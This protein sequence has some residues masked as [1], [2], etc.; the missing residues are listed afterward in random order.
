MDHRD[1]LS[2]LKGLRL[3]GET[4]GFWKCEMVLY[5]TGYTV[6]VRGHGT[7]E[8]AAPPRMEADAEA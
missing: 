2:Y 6:N 4:Y 1:L 8:V 7:L 5:D 3:F